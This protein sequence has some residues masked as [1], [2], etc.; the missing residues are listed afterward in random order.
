MEHSQLL[1][2]SPAHVE[3]PPSSHP[4]F[5]MHS[6]P[7]TRSRK[8][9]ATSSKPPYSSFGSKPWPCAV[10]AAL[11]SPEPYSLL[12]PQCQL[13]RCSCQLQV[14]LILVMLVAGTAS[15][16]LSKAF[17]LSC[18]TPP[19]VQHYISIHARPCSSD[20]ENHCSSQLGAPMVLDSSF[21]PFPERVQ[22]PE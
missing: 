19:K 2:P 21:L 13:L 3:M 22:P 17:P 18:V 9:P 10:I 15:V 12:V 6:S 7:L 11:L 4:N 1:P 5:T 14:I 8:P 16:T 20:T